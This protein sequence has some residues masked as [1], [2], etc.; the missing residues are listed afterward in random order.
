MESV[1]PRPSDQALTIAEA[2]EV[3]HCCMS[4]TLQSIRDLVTR[5]EVVISDHGYDELAADG[6]LVQEI[7]TGVSEAT[8]IED[9]PTYYKGP[10]VLVLQRDQQGQPI[11]VVVGYPAKCVLAS[12]GRDSLSTRSRAMDR[13][14]PEAKSMSKKRH[15]KL[16][17]EGQYAAEVEV[18]WLTSETGWSPYLS[19]E[20][21]QKLDE[22]RQAL[23]R[24]DLK[25]ASQLARVFKLTLITA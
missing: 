6:I 4:Q 22:V 10:C 7:I 23:R 14:F 17:H 9:Y 16:V 3:T 11:H 18:E 5:Q 21:A 20:D 8:V 19:L 15:T 25:R 1:F 24:G 2:R 12:G 13:G